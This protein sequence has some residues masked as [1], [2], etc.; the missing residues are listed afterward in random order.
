MIIIMIIIKYTDYYNLTAKLAM[1]Y[2]EYKRRSDTS[3]MIFPK[4]CK[5][6]SCIWYICNHLPIKL[7]MCIMYLINQWSAS[8]KIVSA[9]HVSDISVRARQFFSEWICSLLWGGCGAHS[10]QKSC[11]HVYVCVWIMVCKCKWHWSVLWYSLFKLSPGKQGKPVSYF[12]RKKAC[13]QSWQLCSNI[14]RKITFL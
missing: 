13:K 14:N 6:T 8:H 10:Q 7:S 4:S 11:T 1:V 12:R 2:S 3:V 9:H 5:C